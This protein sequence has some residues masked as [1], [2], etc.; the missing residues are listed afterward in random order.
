MTLRR[1][2]ALQ[3]KIAPEKDW[4]VKEVKVVARPHVAHNDGHSCMHLRSLGQ[5]DSFA[6][7]GKS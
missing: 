3:C 5:G 6:F 1:G 7:S 4:R 2:N